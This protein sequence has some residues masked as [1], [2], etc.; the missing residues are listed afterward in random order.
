MNLPWNFSPF[1]EAWVHSTA[2]IPYLFSLSS[3]FLF[4]QT[5]Q[6]S[7]SDTQDQLFQFT[8][9]V[10][11][12]HQH[13]LL[14]PFCR[15]MCADFPVC[16]PLPSTCFLSIWIPHDLVRLQKMVLGLG[17]YHGN[18]FELHSLS[19]ILGLPNWYLH[20]TGMLQVCSIGMGV[21]RVPGNTPK[22]FSWLICLITNHLS[23][24]QIKKEKYEGRGYVW[25]VYDFISLT[26]HSI[27]W[28][29]GI[30]YKLIGELK[31]KKKKM[32]EWV[33]KLFPMTNA[34]WAAAMPL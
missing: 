6:G 30:K 13:V 22:A 29:E 4:A 32:T 21:W 17:S 3:G 33:S 28:M 25:P 14:K 10:S 11:G 1:K 18:S 31:I 24:T 8:G 34:L 9:L 2:S 23:Q 19:L 20:I 7:N 15:E 16:K 27:W 26:W 12:H 5:T